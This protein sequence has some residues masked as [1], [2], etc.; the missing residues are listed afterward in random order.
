MTLLLRDMATPAASPSHA[1]HGYLCG[2][3]RRAKAKSGV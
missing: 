3:N 1:V 2:A